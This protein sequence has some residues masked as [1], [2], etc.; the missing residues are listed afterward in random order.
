MRGSCGSWRPDTG[1]RVVKAQ[2]R[3]FRLE[4]DCAWAEAELPAKGRKANSDAAAAAAGPFT[5]DRFRAD[6]P[7]EAYLTK[8]V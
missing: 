5:T 7:D 8:R 4:F 2:A 3:P 1:Q 6:S